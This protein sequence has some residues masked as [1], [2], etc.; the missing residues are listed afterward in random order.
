MISRWKV[1]ECVAERHGKAQADFI[2]AHDNLEKVRDKKI[3]FAELEGNTERMQYRIAR[4]GNDEMA[5]ERISGSIDFQDVY[6]FNLLAKLCKS[7]C[8]ITRDNS[9]LG[10][11]FLVAENILITNNH[12]IESIHDAAN[13]YAEFDYELDD[14]PSPDM[15]TKSVFRIDPSVFFLTS[16]LKKIEGEIYSGLDF[17]LIGVD[18]S[19]IN[20]NKTLKDFP[21]VLLDGNQGKIIKGESCIV[22]QHPEGKPKK[23]VLKDTAFFAETENKIV[24]ESDTM[25][26]SSG[27]MVVGLGT[28]EVIALHHSGLPRT[29]DQNRVMTKAN[30]PATQNTPDDEIDWIGNEGIKVS[31]IIEALTNANL[32]PEMEPGRNQL[33]RKTK[34]IATR[35]DDKVAQGTPLQVSTPVKNESE[36]ITTMNS[37]ANT[38]ATPADFLVT[39]IN[40]LTTTLQITTILR[41]KYGS[42]V[43]FYLAMP[44]AAEENHI[45]LF[46]LR[47]PSLKNPQEEV[48]ELMF[49][50]GILNAEHDIPLALNADKEFLSKPS[51]APT[52]SLGIVDDGYGEENEIKFVNK[53][54]RT[55]PYVINKKPDEYR[56]WNW[57]A[58]GFD[59]V[60]A[61]KKTV[62]PSEA[63]IKLV[64][65][66]TGYSDH[67]KVKGRYDLDHDYNFLDGDSN[68][69]RDAA[70]TGILR[71]PG[72]GTRT[73]SLI[74]GNLLT[75]IPT[76]GNG[77]LLNEYDYKLTPFRISESVILIDRQKQ[78]ASALDMA[79]S[80]G[81]DVITMSM[82]LPPTIATAKMAKKAYDKGVIWCC[83]A[84]NEIQFV[85]APA[86]YPGTIAVAASNPLDRDWTASSRGDAV[87]ITAPGE[88]V[89]VPILINEEGNV[90]EGF[91]YGNGTSYATPHVAAAAACWLAKNKVALNTP[92]YSGWRRVEAFRDALRISGRRKNDLP[93]NGFGHGMLDVE[94]LLTVPL[95]PANK[96]KYAYDDW[97]ENAFFATLQSVAE[98]G[99]TYWNKIHGWIF[100]TRRGGQE[101][102][103]IESMPLSSSSVKIEEALF[104][105]SAVRY[106]SVRE[107]GYD[108]TLERMKK[109]NHLIVSST[110]K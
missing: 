87:D 52:E 53:Y 26:G 84:G 17:T 107:A 39:A 15:K 23:V 8:R 46:V 18:A 91:A 92:A 19:S 55:S 42:G 28:C 77:G 10:T 76:N 101:S 35:L 24:Y 5:I 4:E 58:T 69:A 109:L 34:R 20:N 62:S 97:N 98:I 3:P 30:V 65:F 40:S 61:N 49:I 83:A 67:S 85:I 72:H 105:S 74:I 110:K 57:E 47:I 86:V 27:S 1:L 14:P 68:D 79:L 88:D 102:L 108:D 82:G 89:Y 63:G 90:R 78:L 25:P 51:I 96:L 99:K 44:S 93:R 31:R 54:E 45:E 11:G 32:P 60:I 70:A 38:T 73:S 16:T 41:S 66:D 33:L 43:E 80:Q 95:T 81:F 6:I 75:A 21:A 94:K 22:I 37:A 100:G 71:Q 104:G 2:N 12:V 29:D 13:L 48:K 64:Q 106:E 50:P 7:V 56:K 103:A 9:P 36:K 59:K